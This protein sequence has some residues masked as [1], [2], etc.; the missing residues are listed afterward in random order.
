MPAT[1]GFVP[2]TGGFVPAT[3]GFVPAS[4]GYSTR[5]KIRC[6]VQFSASIESSQTVHGGDLYIFKI[7]VCSKR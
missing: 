5:L 7:S 4:G 2:A 3:G 6:G 1:G